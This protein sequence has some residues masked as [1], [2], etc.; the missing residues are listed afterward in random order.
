[1]CTQRNKVNPVS[2]CC[3]DGL[4]LIMLSQHLRHHYS[5]SEINRGLWN[6][7]ISMEQVEKSAVE[8]AC[9]DPVFPSCCHKSALVTKVQVASS[10]LCMT[11]TCHWL[12][13]N[14]AKKTKPFYSKQKKVNW[15]WLRNREQWDVDLTPSSSKDM[16]AVQTTFMAV[17][18]T[19]DLVCKKCKRQ[20]VFFICI[21]NWMNLTNKELKQNK[22]IGEIGW[23]LHSWFFKR[24]AIG[25]DG[26]HGFQLGWLHAQ[27]S[28]SRLWVGAMLR[29]ELPA[30]ICASNTAHSFIWPRGV[31]DSCVNHLLMVSSL[32]SFLIL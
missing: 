19:A 22:L 5:H 8:S 27:L 16:L 10:V 1:M 7:Q 20:I 2:P 15:I 9:L 23:R 24:R 28:L 17:H 31:G 21:C 12:W 13:M 14:S 18:Q 29:D 6:L 30:S 32:K 11:N 3:H 25:E 26:S 4:T